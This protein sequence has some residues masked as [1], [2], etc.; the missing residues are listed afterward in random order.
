MENCRPG[1][2][3]HESTPAR[4]FSGLEVAHR[5]SE[6]GGGVREVLLK[7]RR[8]R[9][10]Q[11][12]RRASRHVLQRR[13]NLPPS[14]TVAALPDALDALTDALD[15]LPDALDALPDALDVLT[16]ALDV[17]TDAL[18]ALQP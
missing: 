14:G 7:A 18:D 5:P 1:R 11:A 3:E 4:W 9:Y 6:D 10:A 16:D 13:R 17:L 2:A 8:L 12:P 15:A